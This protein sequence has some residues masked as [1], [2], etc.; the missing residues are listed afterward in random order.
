MTAL[1]DCVQMDETGRNDGKTSP[2]ELEELDQRW[3]VHLSDLSARRTS[4][5]HCA[6]GDAR[7]LLIGDIRVRPQQ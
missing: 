6:A 1:N 4:F 7:E 5:Y 3:T 2:D